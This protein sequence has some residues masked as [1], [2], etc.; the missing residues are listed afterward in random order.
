MPS[1]YIDTLSTMQVIGC[2]FNDISLLDYTD[3]YNIVEED[4]CN[5]FHKIVFGSIYKLH[6][7]GVKTITIETIVDFLSSRPKHL[8]IFQ[9]QK[10]EEWLSKVSENAAAATFDYYYNRLKKF[11]LLRAYDNFGVDV[12]DIYDPDNIFDTKKKQSQEDYLDNSSLEQLAQKVELRIDAIRSQYVDNEYDESVQAASG[13]KELV[14][15][16]KEHPEVGI[17][18]YGPLINTVTRGARLKKFYLRSAATGIGK[19]R[20]MIADACYIACD[21]IY[22]ENFGW[23]SAGIN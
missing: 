12:T 23:I 10:G 2:V 5:D 22:D 21:K 20:T 7:L 1:K 9:E 19:T 3:R 15:R 6:E 18:L 17:P 16:L 4:F 14:Q 8:G 11:T 13:I